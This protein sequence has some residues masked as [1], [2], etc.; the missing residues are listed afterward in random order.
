MGNFHKKKNQQ[1]RETKISSARA[2]AEI[3]SVSG[4]I[5]KREE[6]VDRNKKKP[7]NS[8]E[9]EQSIRSF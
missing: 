7:K 6:N 1:H 3:K 9:H 8:I 5:R 2:I 4:A